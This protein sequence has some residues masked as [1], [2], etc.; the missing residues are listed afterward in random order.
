[1]N[2]FQFPS[3]CSFVCF[4]RSTS[5]SVNLICFYFC[6][7]RKIERSSLE[8][9]FIYPLLAQLLV[10]IEAHWRNTVY[11]FHIILKKLEITLAF[12]SGSIT[13]LF[14]CFFFL[15]WS[16]NWRNGVNRPSGRRELQLSSHARGFKYHCDGAYLDV[17]IVIQIVS[18]PLPLSG[19]LACITD[20]CL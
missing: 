10:A 6:C 11:E 7:G 2:S 13:A 3:V 4:L 9:N 20:V 18:H 1:M 12:R 15:N 16:L 5:T 17:A 14:L 19:G 8:E